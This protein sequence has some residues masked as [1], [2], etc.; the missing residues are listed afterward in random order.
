MVA[1]QRHPSN[2]GIRTD[3]RSEGRHPR[4]LSVDNTP[5]YFGQALAGR[6]RLKGHLEGDLTLEPISEY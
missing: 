6:E 2:S 4:V 1:Q 5:K 3:K